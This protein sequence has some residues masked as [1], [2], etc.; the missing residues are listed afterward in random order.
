MEHRRTAQPG[1]ASFIKLCAVP[2]E[3]FRNH[4]RIKLIPS[5]KFPDNDHL[6]GSHFLRSDSR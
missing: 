4:Y 5:G 2:K 1:I 6:R 3:P